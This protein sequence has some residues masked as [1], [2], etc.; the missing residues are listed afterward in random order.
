MFD[1]IKDKIKEMTG[2]PARK[3]AIE[4]LCEHLRLIGLNATV[5][6]KEPESL[7]IFS[8]GQVIGS[9]NVENRNIDQVEL[10]E[11][12]EG[13]G[14]SPSGRTTAPRRTLYRCNYVVRA[15]VEGIEDKLTAEANPVKKGFLSKEIVDFKWEGKELAQILNSDTNL[16]NMMYPP[17][18]LALKNKGL[19]QLPGVEI[20]PY[21]KHECVRISQKYFYY[22]PASAFPTIETFEACDRIA[23]QVRSIACGRP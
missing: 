22:N 12:H 18:K 23:Q 21:E 6:S 14:R 17:D 10:E 8:S 1:K 19:I 7:G 5:E 11:R 13:G 9:V 20:K 4:E 16:K 3:A 15:K 2:E